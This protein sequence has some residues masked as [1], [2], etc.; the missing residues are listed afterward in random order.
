MTNKGTLIAVSAALA[1]GLAAGWYLAPGSPSGEL[2][3]AGPQEREIAYWVA[4][5]DPSYRRDE[6]G[7]SPTGMD[8]IPIYAGDDVEGEADVVRI[9]S[10]VVQ[11]IGV[12]TF[13][14]QRGT[15][16]R[17]IETVGFVAADEERI[18]H[19]H[20]RSSGWIEDLRIK[21]EG[22]EVA[23][24]DLLFRFYSPEI[25]NAQSELVQ[26]LATSNSSLIAASKSRLNALDVPDE[27]ISRIIASGEADELVDVF[28]PQ[29]GIVIGLNVAE[30]TH[31]EPGTTI[32]SLAD[33]NSVWINAEVFEDEAP[34]LAEGAA[35][36]VS[37]PFLP[38]RVWTGSVA[39]VYPTIDPVTRTVRA[40]LIF[41]N[42]D[43]ALKLNMYADVQI[44]AEMLQNV[45]SIPREA[46]I[47]TGA[48]NHV[49]E[50]LGEGRFRRVAVTVGIESGERVQIISGLDAGTLVVTSGQFLIDA[51]A[52]LL[53][54]F[55]RMEG[56]AE[57]DSEMNMDNGDME[58][59]D[60]DQG[61]I[62]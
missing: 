46:L 58:N 14:A 5:M 42:S 47:Q 59:D 10:Q 19:I 49:I 4:P 6:P 18:S 50:A 21:A 9:A 44:A 13:R 40:R 56:P 60:M 57:M 33:L 34:W 3:G 30:G 16:S 24:G 36:Y 25:S 48:S 23:K 26:A 22:E 41:D 1:I 39:Y 38:E 52:S 62:R 43:M 31:I 53:A 51:E 35:A 2:N 55:S 17:E 11:N 8:L 7:K 61:E 45:I 27:Q 12:R 28:A 20:V 37:V 15:I 54:S 29:D 32:F